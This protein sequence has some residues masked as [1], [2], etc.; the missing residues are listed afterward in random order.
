MKIHKIENEAIV[1]FST[2]S[3]RFTVQIM[4]PEGLQNTPCHTHDNHHP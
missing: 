3:L 4:Q 2:I 1:S